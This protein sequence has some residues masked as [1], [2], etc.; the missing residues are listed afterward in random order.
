MI[1]DVTCLECL[2]SHQ[3]LIETVDGYCCRACAR[4]TTAGLAAQRRELRQ[5]L[6]LREFRARVAKAEQLLA[7]VA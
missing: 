5:R 7:A 4:L 6:G 1:E 3:D 2:R